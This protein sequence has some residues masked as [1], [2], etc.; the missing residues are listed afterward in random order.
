MRVLVKSQ[1]LIGLLLLAGSAEAQPWLPSAS[2]AYGFLI[3]FGWIAGIAFFVVAFTNA[4]IDLKRKLWGPQPPSSSEIER[5]V[6]RI[7][8]RIHVR[9]SDGERHTITYDDAE[10]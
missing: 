9:G 4:S 5:V 10:D 2:Y 7:L 6:D 1:G 3:M 8:K